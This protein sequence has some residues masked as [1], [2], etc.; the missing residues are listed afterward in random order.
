MNDDYDEYD[1]GPGAADIGEDD[2]YVRCPECGAE[3]Y[4]EA[5]QCA[6]C[7]YWMVGGVERW[8]PKRGVVFKVMAW[9]LILSF[10]LTFL[11][12]L[13]SFFS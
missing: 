1:E 4:A 6:G 12:A 8:T 11:M 9:L 5:E 10:L 3:V 13:V 2:D 7:G